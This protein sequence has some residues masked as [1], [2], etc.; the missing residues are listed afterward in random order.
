M[1][2]I[3]YLEPDEEITSVIDKVKQ[4]K[5]K[6]LALVVP[7]E[8]TLLQ[9]VVNL[10]LLLREAANSGK[11][12][13]LVTADKIGRNLAAQI[14][15]VVYDSIKDRRPVFQPPAPTPGAEEVIEIDM[16]E[17]KKE[18]EPRPKGIQIHHFQ[19]EKS[20]ATEAK[21]WTGPKVTASINWSKTRKIVWP[22]LAVVG[23]LLLVVAFLTLPKVS[24]KV[25]V[26]SEN[27]ARAQDVQVSA[28][29][30]TNLD[31]QIFAGNLID[32]TQEKEE[33]FLA[34][35][36]KNLGGKATGTLTLYNYWDSSAQGLEK[37][38]KF[39][40]SSK[41]FVSKNSVTIP[42]TSI[43]GG[44]IVPGT[45]TVEIEA[46]NPGEEYNVKAGRFSIVGLPAA[47]QEKI[48]GQASKDLSGGFSKEVTVVSQED[49]DQAKDKLSK[50][51]EEALQQKLTEE[52][53]RMEILEKAIQIEIIETKSSTDVEV[54]A[55]EFTFKVRE[56]L[57]V[58]VFERAS[59]D[60][61]VINS[62]EKQ[63]PYDKMITLGPNDSIMPAEIEPKYDQGQ[64][65]LKVEVTAKISSRVDTEK[66][67]KDLVG[68]GKAAAEEYLDNLAGA[69][70]FQIKFSPSFWLKRIPNYTRSLKVEL[71]YLPVA[72]STP[73]SIPS[74]VTS[75][76][77]SPTLP[78]STEAIE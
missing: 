60:E 75:P 55:N 73:S 36:K 9:S 71:E 33:K 28:E 54:E 46:E 30:P 38:S 10:K 74:P 72:E 78:S 66:I 13:A 65:N 41:T 61:F 49:F 16:A 40:S 12:I 64:L 48:Y 58:M 45:A 63:I 39:S 1:E 59:F 2:E 20:K 67:K 22:M 77:V 5:S 70:G 15:L 69:A 29:E 31:N 43:R 11:E 6:R 27:F 37:G 17:E 4:A 42:G 51:I 68:K 25:Q 23:L 53:Q 8:A 57:R 47:Q 26:K 21:P 52:A 14:G 56:R 44:N 24:I 62:L 35:G 34:T 3:L 18:E 32:L 7:R 76:E 50:V 19:K